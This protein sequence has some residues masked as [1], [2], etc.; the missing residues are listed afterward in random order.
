MNIVSCLIYVL[1]G[2]P[3]LI[4]N[5]YFLHMDRLFR[6]FV[7]DNSPPR[8]SL[9]KLRLPFDKDSFNLSD[10]QKYHWAYIL[11]AI[12]TRNENLVKYHPLWTLLERYYLFLLHSWQVP[13]ST[14]NRKEVLLPRKWFGWNLWVFVS[15]GNQETQIVQIYIRI[16]CKLKLSTK[17]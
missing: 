16:Y 2:I 1:C 12:S 15:C 17:I 5:K 13:G 14:D 4:P 10:L 3:M 9:A 7:L 6:K 8:I 11:L